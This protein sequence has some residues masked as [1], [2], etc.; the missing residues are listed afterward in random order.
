VVAPDSVLVR[1]YKNAGLGSLAGKS[2]DQK[3]R[4]TLIFYYPLPIAKRTYKHMLLANLKA[5]VLL[6]ALLSSSSSLK[7]SRP[8]P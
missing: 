1:T 2:R 6:Q 8:S 7:Q 3:S 5:G 4:V